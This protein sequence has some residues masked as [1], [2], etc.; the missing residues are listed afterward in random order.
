MIINIKTDT[1]FWILLATIIY[2]ILVIICVICCLPW[3]G[4]KKTTGCRGTSHAKIVSKKMKVYHKTYV[5]PQCYLNKMLKS[6]K[7]IVFSNLI[8]AVFGAPAPTI[9]LSP[10]GKPKDSAYLKIEIYKID[11]KLQYSRKMEKLIIQFNNNMSLNSN[12]FYDDLFPMNWYYVNPRDINEFDAFNSFINSVDP[13][14][15][16]ILYNIYYNSEANSYLV[17]LEENEYEVLLKILGS[18]KK[19]KRE[20]YIITLNKTIGSFSCS[21][22]DYTYRCQQKGIVCKHISFV[23]CKVLKL[24]DTNV[25]RLNKLSSEQLDKSITL[26]KSSSVWKNKNI[27]TRYINYEFKH[28]NRTFDENEPCPICYEKLGNIEILSCPDCS[29]YVHTTCMK[30]WLSQLDKTCIYCRSDKWYDFDELI[31]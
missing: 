19:N 21:C 3:C 13:L 8:Q 31:S 1:K 23:L 22:K 14:Q 30:V 18:L 9:P 25:F 17:D 2:M 11:C 12:N 26:L 4:N 6:V 27:S 16:D 24:L 5:V 29:N 10:F 28:S 7:I 15:Q 20:S